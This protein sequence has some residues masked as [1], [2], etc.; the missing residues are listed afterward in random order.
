VLV[1]LSSFDDLTLQKLYH[2]FDVALTDK[3]GDEIENFLVDLQGD[4]V[5][6]LDD[7]ENVCDVVFEHFDVVFAELKDLFKYYDLH[8]VVVVFLEKV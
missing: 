6:I 2:L 4:H 1:H 8:V 5:V 7:S 3:V